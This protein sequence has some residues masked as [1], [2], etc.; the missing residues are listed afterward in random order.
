MFPLALDGTVAKRPEDVNNKESIDVGR[1]LTYEQERKKVTGQYT[2][3]SV[4]GEL[5]VDLLHSLDVDAAG[6]SVVH[7]GLGVMHADD[8][9]GSLLHSLRSVPGIVDVL[10]WES[11][12]NGQVAPE[13]RD[14]NREGMWWIIQLS[15]EVRQGSCRFQPT[16]I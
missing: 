11:S 4:T 12:Q 14:G 8:A 5:L 3:S 10:R 6:L 16:Q 7:H 15:K 9:F 13:Q 1:C 2:K